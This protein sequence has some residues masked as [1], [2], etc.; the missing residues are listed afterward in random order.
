MT[1]YLRTDGPI[2]G[3][4]PRTDI[5]TPRPTTRLAPV[6]T[7]TDPNWMQQSACANSDDPNAWFPAGNTGFWLQHIEDTKARC[8]ATCPVLAQCERLLKHL[9]SHGEVGGIWAGT[10]EADRTSEKRRAQRQQA[11][12]RYNEKRR[13]AP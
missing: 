11:K 5:P 13:S 4:T 9:E 1:P 3:R 2:S 12:V 6:P 7:E 8:L 10:S